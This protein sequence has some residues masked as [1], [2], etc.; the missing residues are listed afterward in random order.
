M[1]ALTGILLVLV[2]MTVGQGVVSALFTKLKRQTLQA[3]ATVR[4]GLPSLVCPELFSEG[5]W[6]NDDQRSSHH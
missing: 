3:V 6:T 2:V 1:L 5:L 4:D